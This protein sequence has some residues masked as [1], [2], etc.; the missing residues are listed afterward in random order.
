MKKFKTVEGFIKH[1][2]IEYTPLDNVNINGVDYVVSDHV[3]KIDGPHKF[4]DGELVYTG[5][6]GMK[7]M[8]YAFETREI[9]IKEMKA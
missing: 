5:P 3:I 2:T 9:K 6:G 8:A 4:P 1:M 7:G